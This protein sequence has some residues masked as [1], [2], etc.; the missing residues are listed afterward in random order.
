M[1]FAALCL[2]LSLLWAVFL[3]SIC[4]DIPHTSNRVALCVPCRPCHACG[5]CGF[6]V[7]SGDGSAVDMKRRVV[8]SDPHAFCRISCPAVLAVRFDILFRHISSFFYREDTPVQRLAD[9]R[10]LLVERCGYLIK[11]NAGVPITFQP[12]LIGGVARFIVQQAIGFILFAAARCPAVLIYLHRPYL[13]CQFFGKILRG[14]ALD[15]HSVEHLPYKKACVN[16][17]TPQPCRNIRP[18]YR[19]R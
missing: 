7:C 9:R 12:C 2:L 16:I 18:F 4:F 14:S 15:K 3:L 19:R 5:V 1:Y 13:F 8:Y 10:G 17:L 11:G 6:V